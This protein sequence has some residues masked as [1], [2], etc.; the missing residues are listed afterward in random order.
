M[1]IVLGSSAAANNTRKSLASIFKAIDVPVADTGSEDIDLKTIVPTNQTLVMGTRSLVKNWVEI[2]GSD[3]VFLSS[4]ISNECYCEL[5]GQ[6]N[7]LNEYKVVNVRDLDSSD[8]N[9]YFYKEINSR[10]IFKAGLYTATQLKLL[11][12]T[13]EGSF[14]VGGVLQSSK[15]RCMSEYRFFVLDGKIVGKCRYAHGPYMD[16]SSQVPNSLVKYAE[17]LIPKIPMDGFVIDI[18][19]VDRLG[20]KVI[21]VNSF[22]LAG[23]HGIDLYDF[24]IN[25]KKYLESRNVE[26]EV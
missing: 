1:L 20:Y 10:G 7:M 21:E 4:E 13:E 18:A 22:S 11:L 15:K 25:V 26:S 24:A 23:W 5:L 9:T 19:H 14:K 17:S 3:N 8:P 2:H 6:E 12:R 16:V